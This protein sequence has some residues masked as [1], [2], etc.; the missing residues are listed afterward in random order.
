MI[1][2]KVHYVLDP[3]TLAV[4]VS[5]ISIVLFSVIL[6]LYYI[7]RNRNERL[8]ETYLCGESEKAF[9]NLS[10]SVSSLYWGFM[11]KFAKKIYDALIN[12]VHTGNIQ[13]WAMFITSWMGILILISILMFVLY[14]FM[15]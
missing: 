1:L 3:G 11:K 8:T 10:P 6:I 5:L 14:V 2:M 7:L 15:R 13:D 9:S 12:L 4:L